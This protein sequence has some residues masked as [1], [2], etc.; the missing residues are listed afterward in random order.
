M[1]V[2]AFAAIGLVE[3]LKLKKMPD[4]KDPTVGEIGIGD[5]VILASGL[6]R[7]SSHDWPT[8]LQ[9]TATFC[10]LAM[11]ACAF[12]LWNGSIVLGSDR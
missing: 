11:L 3:R 9:V 6:V 12:L 4:V 7:E 5:L 2:G 8:V 1:W 10:P